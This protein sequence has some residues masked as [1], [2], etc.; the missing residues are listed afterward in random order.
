MEPFFDYT[1]FCYPGP[2]LWLAM[3]GP[4]VSL[5]LHCLQLMRLP[6]LSSWP[7]CEETKKE[8]PF[9]V[10]NSRTISIQLSDALL[11]NVRVCS[12]NTFGFPHSAV[13]IWHIAGCCIPESE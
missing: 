12:V 2:C 13:W 8:G 7:L 11:K 6:S 3:L 4:T 10:V 5:V 9:H 1:Y